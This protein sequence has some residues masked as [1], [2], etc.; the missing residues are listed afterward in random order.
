M[1]LSSMFDVDLNVFGPVSLFQRVRCGAIFYSCYIFFQTI[2]AIGPRE[3]MVY[4]LYIVS[5]SA[6]IC[7]GRSAQ[8]REQSSED[9]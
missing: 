3:H 2:S 8:A 6:S 1:D 9:V 4:L 5:I 7:V